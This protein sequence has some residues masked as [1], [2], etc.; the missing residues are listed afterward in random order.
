MVESRG[1]N[2][3]VIEEERDIVRLVE[4]DIEAIQLITHS[5]PPPPPPPEPGI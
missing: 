1:R 4:R 2:G 5:F 3:G